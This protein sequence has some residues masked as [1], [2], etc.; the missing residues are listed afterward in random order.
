MLIYRSRIRQKFVKGEMDMATQ[1]NKR[2]SWTATIKRW[3]GMKAEAANDA[4]DGMVD[5]EV[6][7][8]RKKREL[9]ERRDEIRNGDNMSQILGLKAQLENDLIAERR[10]F[11]QSKYIETIRRLRDT[12]QTEQ[13]KRL[14][15]EKNQKEQKIETLVQQLAEA[16]NAEAEILRQLDILDRNIAQATAELDEFQRRNQMAQ[17]TEAIYDVLNSVTDINTGYDADGIHEAIA[18]RERAAAGRRTLYNNA[19]IASNAR[20]DA[21]MSSLDDELA[22]L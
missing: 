11:E 16:T 3:F 18:E 2:K 6:Q 7:L 12:G 5:L 10:K 9:L 17:Q 14:L 8:K 4:M 21:E 13:A 19:N 22:N 1:K 20:Y 15:I